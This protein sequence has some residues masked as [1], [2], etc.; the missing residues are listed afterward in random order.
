MKK[1]KKNKKCNIFVTFD[2][3]V[4]TELISKSVILVIFMNFGHE[5]PFPPRK[6]IFR[7]SGR[8]K[9]ESTGPK[10]GPG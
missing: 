7:A 8:C 4:P 3:N 9:F 6:L 5:R 2:K 10:S 1:D